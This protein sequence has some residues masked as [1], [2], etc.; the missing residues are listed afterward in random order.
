M[1]ERM[2]IIPAIDLR[3]G[4]CVRLVQGDYD[5]CTTYSTT[6][7]AIAKDFE[8]AG[9]KRLHLVDLDGAKAGEIKN[10][11]TLADLANNTS[12]AIDFSGGVK[13][14]DSLR[15]ALLAG[16]DYVGIGSLAYQNPELVKSWLQEFGSYRIILSADVW[17]EKI[18]IMGWTQRTSTTIYEFIDGF[19]DK[20]EYLVCTDISKDGMLEGP[21]LD[22]YKALITRYPKLKI[23]A[24]GGVSSLEDLDKL[25][26]LGV[27]GVIIGK[28]IYENKIT[29]N[30]LESWINK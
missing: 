23:I 5:D 12:L 14:E 21:S 29:L 24:S 19:E 9:L 18:A 28:A 1:K 11:K 22:L 6:P 8:R 25:D 15:E 16:A 26:E 30:Q 4:N 17:D 27:Y 13:S 2:I 7:L 3:D 20:L 10:L